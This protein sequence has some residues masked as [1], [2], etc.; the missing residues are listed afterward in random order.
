MLASNLMRLATAY[1]GSGVALGN[2]F[3]GTPV[4][5]FPS[6]PTRPPFPHPLPAKF[7][8]DPAKMA[9][10]VVRRGRQDCSGKRPI[11]QDLITKRSSPRLST[12]QGNF[13]L[14]DGQA[15]FRCWALKAS[16]E[17]M[18]G[19]AREAAHHKPGTY[20]A[21]P[22]SAGGLGWK[23]LAGPRLRAAGT[24]ATPSEMPCFWLPR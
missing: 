11:Q 21:S 5:T 13:G 4:V 10:G 9:R 14:G 23:L 18:E 3:R 8:R 6:C 15:P 1:L 22:W 12:R 20:C 2:E 16:S 24:E 19:W 7:L 17:R